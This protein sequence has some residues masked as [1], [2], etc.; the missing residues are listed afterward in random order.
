MVM[1][2]ALILSAFNPIGGEETGEGEN[3]TEDGRY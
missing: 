3:M 2:V 1:D